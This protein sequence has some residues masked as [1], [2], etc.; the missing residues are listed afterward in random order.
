MTRFHSLFN[1]VGLHAYL[2]PYDIVVTSRS[3][4]FIE[5]ISD[6]VSID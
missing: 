3:A 4:G 6:T 5:Y 1:E 2:R